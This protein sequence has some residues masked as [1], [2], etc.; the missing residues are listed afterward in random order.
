ML[1]EKFTQ[2]NHINVL[3]LNPCWCTRTDLGKQSNFHFLWHPHKYLQFRN[4]RL[5][6]RCR[7]FSILSRCTLA[8]AELIYLVPW[9]VKLSIIMRM[10][11]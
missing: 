1:E 5:K 10:H 11:K 7:Q 9:L 4:N 8:Y 3:P 6:L 2:A